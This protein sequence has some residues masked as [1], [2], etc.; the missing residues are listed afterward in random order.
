MGGIEKPS[1]LHAVGPQTLCP[2]ACYMC[3]E[4]L[5]PEPL[6]ANPLTLTPRF[7]L[8]RVSLVSV[9]YS[10][11]PRK[12]L[13]WCWEL[14]KANL[15]PP[16]IWKTWKINICF[17]L[18]GIEKPAK[19]SQNKQLCR[20]LLTLTFRFALFRFSQ[21]RCWELRKDYLDPSPNAKN[22]RKNICFKPG[23]GVQKPSKLSQN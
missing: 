14:R 2:T 3:P 17:K 10:T 16:Q 9:M 21:R 15:D 23:G 12:S 7:A 4:P 22:L 13:S 6:S 8:F 1:N 20:K 5:C 18:G 11:P 19:L